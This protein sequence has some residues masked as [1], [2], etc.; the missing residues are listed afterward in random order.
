MQRRPFFL[1]FSFLS[2]PPSPIDLASKQNRNKKD[3]FHF[4][5]Y[6]KLQK[7]RN[8]CNIHVQTQKKKL[9]PVE[10]LQ[11]AFLLFLSLPSPYLPTPVMR[12]GHDL[13]TYSV[14]CTL[15]TTV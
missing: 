11:H 13:T 6:V 4:Q 15:F 14:T 9:K 5:R 10:G 7:F 2:V 12:W 1:Q 3:F 8:W